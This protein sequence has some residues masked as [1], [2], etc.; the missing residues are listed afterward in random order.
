MEN[1]NNKNSLEHRIRIWF[2]CDCDLGMGLSIL[3]KVKIDNRQR[4]IIEQAP[5]DK[6]IELLRAAFRTVDHYTDRLSFDF[7]TVDYMGLCLPSPAVTL[8]APSPAVTL[9]A[10]PLPS[11]G[12]NIQASAPN[13]QPLA[14]LKDEKTNDTSVP[15][16]APDT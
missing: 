10:P 8:D 7:N 13:L 3:R 6:V 11:V 16:D 15:D 2:A 4:D 1:R 5:K 9:D 14:I 12:I